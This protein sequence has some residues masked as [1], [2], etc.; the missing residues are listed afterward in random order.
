MFASI[1][2]LLGG[3]GTFLIGLKMMGD[4]LQNIA[5]DRLKLLFNKVSNNKFMGI[6]TGAG[7][8][9]VIQSSSAT[10]VMIVGFVNAGMMTLK[11]A[12]SIIM[13]ANIGT[14]IT[15]QITALQ[16][17]P[18]TPFLTAFACVGAFMAMFGKDKIAKAGMLISGIGI[19]FVGMRVMSTSMD[20]VSKS[21]E[22]INLLASVTHP[23]LLMLIGLVFTAVFQSS[24]A[25]TSILI[26]LCSVSLDEGGQLMTLQ[27]AIFV[28]LG[29]NIGTCVTAMLA[30]IGANTNAKRASVI[31]LLFNVF[32]TAIFLI[33]IFIAPLISEKL[34]IHYWLAKAFPNVVS[35]QIAMFHTIFNILSTLI[36][37]PFTGG[38][39]KLATILVREKKNNQEEEKDKIVAY[40]D[41]RILK[42][43]SIA[44]MVL[45]KELLSMAFLAKTNFDLSIETLANLNFDKSK[46]F[47]ERE[48]RI[49][50]LNKKL[51]KFAV[52]I[53]AKDISYKE[54]KEIASFYHVISDIERVGD[55]AENICESA[56]ELVDNNLTFSNTAIEEIKMMKGAIDKL[57]EFV[58]QAFEQK[59]MSLKDEVNGYEDL[60]DTYEENLSKNHIVRLHNNDCSA[61]SGGIF[62]SI[63]SNMERVADHFRNVFTSMSTY[64]TPIKTKANIKE[65][66]PLADIDNNDNVRILPS[67][68]VQPNTE[69]NK[70]VTA[71][72][73]TNEKEDK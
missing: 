56:H 65:E 11:Q 10:T 6:A 60:V 62:L 29:I 67:A 52:K 37:L 25:T 18:I 32:G 68:N 7:I 50:Y 66:T 53:S 27:S 61:E 21:P 69:E 39:T 57:Y 15:A 55:Y 4:N 42:S 47:E 24:A 72:V 63:I 34:A 45:R 48:K 28:T 14:T 20:D 59:S 46:E 31:H 51:T 43:P 12:T 71:Q 8:T 22:V 16:S 49:D 1:L 5:G 2:L 58:M 30:S 3:L 38:L 23:L 64:V 36:L 70:E 44:L 26:T 9:A 35:T 17:L 54:E 73:S 41:E 40:I 33:F 13:G 19:I